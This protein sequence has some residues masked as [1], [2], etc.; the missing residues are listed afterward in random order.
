MN[1]IL[2]KNQLAV[3]KEYEYNKPLIQKID[4]LNDNCY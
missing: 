3:V 2:N 4:S 1:G